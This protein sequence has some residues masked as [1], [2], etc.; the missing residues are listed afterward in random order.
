MENS[1][2]NKRALENFVTGDR[3]LAELEALV[4]RFN[5]FEAL[6][7]VNAEL[8]HSSFL[9]FL[10]NPRES[11][12][13]GDLIL[14]R[15]L[16]E[17]LQVNP[18]VTSL[19]P[20]EIH[21]SDFSDCEVQTE[22]GNIDILLSPSHRFLVIIENKVNSDQHDDQ[23]ARYYEQ[24]T[25]NHPDFDV[26]GIHLTR[27]SDPSGHPRY[28]ALPHASVC[29]VV[30]EIMSMPRVTVSRDVEMARQYTEM[31]GSSRR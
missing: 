22:T 13:L 1:A 5:V 14:K 20:I 8:R 9:A 30:T 7:V 25:L 15:L 12:G 16:Q 31:L 19:T 6:G 27:Y 21:V 29:K 26:F 2:S 11:H 18:E 3:D 24:T 4:S 28:A 10:L 17:T 23:L